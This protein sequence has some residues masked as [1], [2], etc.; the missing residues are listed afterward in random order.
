MTRASKELLI[1]LLVGAGVL[2]L[3][4]GATATRE[5]LGGI[6]NPISDPNWTII[7]TGLGAIAVSVILGFL[8]RTKKA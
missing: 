1:V 8:V 5:P 2:L 7:G 3:L 6:G 4:W